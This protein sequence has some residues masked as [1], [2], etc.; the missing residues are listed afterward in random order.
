MPDAEQRVIHLTL[1]TLKNQRG[2]LVE[3]KDGR[4]FIPAFCLPDV[5]RQ[6][7]GI[8]KKMEDM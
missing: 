3:S 6:L 7:G 1:G 8:Q 5:R 4:V 2:V